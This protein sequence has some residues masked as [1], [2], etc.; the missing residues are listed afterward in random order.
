MSCVL[1]I[2]AWIDE[3]EFRMARERN[4]DFV[5]LDVNERDGEFFKKFPLVKEYSR[6]YDMPIGALGRW[7]TDRITENGI[8]KGELE[9]ECKL[10]DAA[11]ELSCDVYITGCNFVE[12]LS[13]YENCTLAIEYLKKLADYGERAGV[14]VATYN[15]R[16]NNFVH[17]PKAWEMIHGQVQNLYIKYDTSHCI[18][19]G[20]DYLKECRDW[21]HRFAHVHIK[22]ALLVDGERFDDPPAGL[23]QTDFPSVVAI[24]YAK[25]YDGKLSMEPHSEYWQG[26]LGQKGIDYTVKYMRQLLL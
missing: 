7:G 1:G 4:L 8:N 21:A 14:K 10:I 15:C 22:G 12:T 11:K 2:I 6:K 23:D 3:E 18:Y 13:F 17:S 19:A 5:E 25:G 26:E 24:L 20:G 9:T 16:W